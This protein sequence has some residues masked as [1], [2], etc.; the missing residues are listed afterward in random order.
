M[1]DIMLDLETLGTEPNAI[2]LSIG[3]VAFDYQNNKLGPEFY[4][5]ISVLGS[6][7]AGYQY[8]DST[9][10]WWERQ[11]PVAR[12]VLAEALT[13][14]I[15]PYAACNSVR[16]Y[17]Q[18]FSPDVRV[19]GNGAAFDNEL[20]RGYLRKHYPVPLWKF[21]ND[22]CY[23]TLNALMAARVEKTDPLASR[24]GT[25]HNALDDAKTQALRAMQM[26]RLM[27]AEGLPL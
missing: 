15:T 3:M 1:Q 23:R 8:S 7:A 9:L 12:G 20:L 21:W 4:T 11:T 25:H 19:W 6:V 26:L 24:V 17:L 13:T 5:P 2:I 16:E 22:R 14:A 18:Q 10:I 27:E